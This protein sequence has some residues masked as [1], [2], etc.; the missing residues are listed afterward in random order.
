M[1]NARSLSCAEAT[2]YM[3]NRRLWC[4]CACKHR[5]NFASQFDCLDPLEAVVIR[6]LLA[7]C[8]LILGLMS[9]RETMFE[10]PAPAEDYAL[11]QSQSIYS[12]VCTFRVLV[13]MNNLV[14]SVLFPRGIAAEGGC[15]ADSTSVSIRKVAPA[16]SRRSEQR[17]TPNVLLRCVSVRSIRC[18]W[19]RRHD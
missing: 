17:R 5:S 1:F 9:P 10:C 18:C 12:S 2:A 11:Y 13:H 16:R 4:A 19:R 7:A 3:R 6:R 8:V 15:S 14:S